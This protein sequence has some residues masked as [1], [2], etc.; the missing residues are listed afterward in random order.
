MI[1]K[2]KIG[3]I[4]A[5]RMGS[6][7]LPGKVMMPLLGI[8]VITFL[9]NRLKESKYIDSLV[10]A[11]SIAPENKVL[12]EE[13]NNLGISTFAGDMNEENVLQRYVMAESK[14][15]FDYVVR[16]TA[17]C[18]F[19]NGRV[20]DYILEAGFKGNEFPDLITGKPDFPSG[21]DSEIYKSKSINQIY[22]D[23]NLIAGDN[24][25]MLNFIYR[26]K[27]DFN[28]KYIKPPLELSK[29]VD[30]IFLLDTESDYKSICK[31]LSTTKDPL[32]SPELILEN[33]LKIN[34]Y[35][36]F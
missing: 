18:P 8:P 29:K 9:I 13:A 1:N 23:K 5:A 33:Y 4:I 36:D 12:I 27:S 21:L 20:I 34:K 7:R 26:N 17:D 19:L 16:V 32:I 31:I 22:F 35:Y 28:I 24:E 14:F 25:H 30:N 15:K 11:T 3:A 10:L 2:Q 6:S